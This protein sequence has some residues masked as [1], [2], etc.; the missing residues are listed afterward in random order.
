MVD[1]QGFEVAFFAL[2]NY[3]QN[4]HFQVK[5][6]CLTVSLL[7]SHQVVSDSATPWTVACQAP[8]SM[9][10]SRQEYWNGLPLPT[11]GGIP[12]PGIKPVSLPSPSLAGGFFT[13][14]A[15]WEAPLLHIRNMLNT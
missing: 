6:I 1:S 7:F 14:S 12:D 5:R 2:S 3:P 10:F 15:T 8:L 4:V 9:E 13:V 11:P